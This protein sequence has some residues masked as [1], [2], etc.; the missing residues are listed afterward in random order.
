MDPLVVSNTLLFL[1]LIAVSC[2][3]AEV[4]KLN[5]HKTSDR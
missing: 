2:V 5:K 4:R 1:I 3:F